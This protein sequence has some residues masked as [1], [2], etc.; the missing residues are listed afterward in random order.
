M[1]LAW[2]ALPKKLPLRYFDSW[3][4]RY[5]LS[6]RIERHIVKQCQDSSTKPIFSRQLANTLVDL[7]TFS[8]RGLL[9][10]LGD[11]D[12]LQIC[13]V[14]RQYQEVPV[15]VLVRQTLDQDLA[16]ALSPRHI[17]HAEKHV[18]GGKPQYEQRVK[19]MVTFMF[20]KPLAKQEERG[21]RQHT[22]LMDSA[23][24]LAEVCKQAAEVAEGSEE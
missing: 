11:I 1:G 5:V 6:S 24:T 22:R 15:Y 3:Y 16:S 2:D 19:E 17:Y 12:L 21:Q 7:S 10:G 18:F 14:N 9:Q 20:S 8:K 13:D 23:D 4:V